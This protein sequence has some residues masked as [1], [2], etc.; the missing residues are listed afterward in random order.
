MLNVT[1]RWGLALVAALMLLA[2]VIHDA[3]AQDRPSQR[4]IRS[5]IP[6]DQLVSFLPST[7][8]EQFVDFINPIFVRVT[9]KE[10]IDPESSKA[11]IGV[12]IAGLHYFDAFELVLEYNGLMFR[13]TDRYFIVEPGRTPELVQDAAQ[14]TSR[15]GSG[16]AVRAAQLLASLDSREIQIDAVLFEVNQSMARE[17][18]INW[19]VV[20]GDARSQTGS[21]GGTTG[22]TQQQGRF[23]LRTEKLFEP[24]DDFL[25]SP[26]TLPLSEIFRVL[27]TSGVGETIAN[28]T[29]TVQSAEKGRIQIGSDVPIQTRDFSGNTITQFFSTG[30]IVDV[31]PTLITQALADTFNAPT[32]DFI[33]LDVA[34]EKSSSRPSLS[35]PVIDR[36][37]A[38]TKVLLLHGEQTVIG[39]LYSTEE[40]RTRRGI[41]ILK[42]LPPWF[43]GLRYVFGYEQVSTAQKELLIVLQARVVDPIRTRAQRPLDR[44]LLEQ[45]RQ[46]VRRNLDQFSEEVSSGVVLPGGY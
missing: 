29:V 7:P 34:V 38:N 10:V 37:V 40:S 2:P 33:H 6:P 31:T 15:A 20:F 35:G 26:A 19:D 11:P 4:H 1:K 41:P 23:M 28:P 18:G 12:S 36:N 45:R 44:N 5:Y 3:A 30:I 43:F 25:V 13:E 22:S 9:G 39:G 16:G 24:F 17:L 42:D 21:T 46:E 32:L 27:E 14:A 8:F